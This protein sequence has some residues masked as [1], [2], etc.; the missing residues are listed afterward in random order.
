M[1]PFRFEKRFIANWMKAFM[2]SP[3]VL[4]PAAY[5]II[6]LCAS[7]FL[8]T[9]YKKELCRSYGIATGSSR[10]LSIGSLKAGIDL[11]SVTLSDIETVS[12]IS[13]PGKKATGP[14]RSIHTMSI[15]LCDTG[16]FFLS[17]SA[18]QVSARKACEKILAGE[19]RYQ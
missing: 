16:N 8:N 5:L 7:L 4:F 17:K 14:A 1:T 10:N 6:Y 11:G 15:T 3:G 2:V 19:A 9:V 12:A 18:R 13:F